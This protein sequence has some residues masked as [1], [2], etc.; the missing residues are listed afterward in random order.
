LGRAVSA[1]L[2]KGDPAALP[3][4]AVRRSR[5][6]QALHQ[7]SAVSEGNADSL[8]QYLNNEQ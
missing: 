2:K 1:Q 6:G 5:F 3:P 4:L 8:D 7:V